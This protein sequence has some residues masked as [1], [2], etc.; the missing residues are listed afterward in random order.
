M[1]FDV[2]S[3]LSPARET[4]LKLQENKYIIITNR[5]IVELKPKPGV[6]VK[7]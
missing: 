2:V 4:N 3:F 1:W 5:F 6:I 7:N